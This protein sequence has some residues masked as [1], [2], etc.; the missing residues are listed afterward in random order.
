[1]IKI[2][3]AR[4]QYYVAWEFPDVQAEFR[5]GTGTRDHIANIC[6]IIE[7]EREFQKTN[8]QTN[9]STSTSLIML[10]YL[11]VWIPTTEKFL[12]KWEY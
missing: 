4:F 11:T 8:K 12:K 3:Q 9:P 6:W 5:K 1:M 7:K 2:L 10:K